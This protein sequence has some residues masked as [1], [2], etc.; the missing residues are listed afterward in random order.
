MERRA[1]I[2][3]SL[4]PR[5]SNGFASGV[6]P[7]NKQSPANAVRYKIIKGCIDRRWR[8]FQY[9]FLTFAGSRSGHGVVALCPDPLIFILGAQLVA[10][11]IPLITNARQTVMLA[12]IN[13][14]RW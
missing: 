10:E 14:P 3:A 6:L 7:S 11:W 1:V 2:P 12:L 9:D 8:S 5:L 13:A 4:L